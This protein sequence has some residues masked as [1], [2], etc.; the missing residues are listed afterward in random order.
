VNS[1]KPYKAL[2]LLQC[3]EGLIR[4]EMVEGSLPLSDLIDIVVKSAYSQLENLAD[5]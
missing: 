4:G 1:S 3:K 5:L 2:L